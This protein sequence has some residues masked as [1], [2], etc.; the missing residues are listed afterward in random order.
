MIYLQETPANIGFAHI[1]PQNWMNKR[2]LQSTKQYY[3]YYE[4]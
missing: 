1:D 2:A 3:A 4:S